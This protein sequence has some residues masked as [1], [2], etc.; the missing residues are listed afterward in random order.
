VQ[1]H[2]DIIVE[3]EGK[4]EEIQDKKKKT[5]TITIHHSS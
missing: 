3:G 4:Q 5:A 1:Q 2:K